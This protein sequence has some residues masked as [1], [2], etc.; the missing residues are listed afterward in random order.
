MRT[1]KDSHSHSSKEKHDKLNDS[2][3]VA[4]L[5]S[6]IRLSRVTATD[7]SHPNMQDKVLLQPQ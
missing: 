5:V 3:L 1:V 7:R 2:R 4:S 6:P